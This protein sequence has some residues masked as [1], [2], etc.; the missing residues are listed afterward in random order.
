MNS[1]AI[2]A[3][4]NEQELVQRARSQNDVGAFSTLVRQHQGE[5]R[6]FM[7]RLCKDYN[8]ADDLAQE[9]MLQA[10]K[11]LERFRGDCKFS[12]WLFSIGYRCFLQHKRK[13]DRDQTKHDM[14]SLELQINP[15]SYDSISAS[16][17]DLERA[18]LQLSDKERAA[19]SLCFSY[20]CS[21][22]EA[23][24]ILQIPLGTVKTTIAS[25][26]NKLKGLLGTKK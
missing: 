17:L 18:M 19:I 13:A 1:N 22:S 6:T 16:Q 3:S 8:L 4:M 14:L 26:K 25:G 15:G 11:K 10:H 23:S 21:H 2:F 9:T 5:L 7:F 12:T 20:G 24:D